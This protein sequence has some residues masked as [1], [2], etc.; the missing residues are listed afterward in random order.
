[1]RTSKE[2]TELLKKHV[3]YQ[4]RFNK[5]DLCWN[6]RIGF[7]TTNVDSLVAK[8][9][10]MSLAYVV[11]DI[12]TYH[13]FGEYLTIYLQPSTDGQTNIDARFMEELAKIDMKSGV[14]TGE[15]K[16]VDKKMVNEYLKSGWELRGS[17]RGIK[18]T[19]KAKQ[20][21]RE[22]HIG[23]KYMIHPD[24]KDRKNPLPS[25]FQ[26]FLDLGYVFMCPQSKELYG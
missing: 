5:V 22:N 26:K 8:M 15:Y 18:Q 2:I 11:G 19:E 9:Y 14:A 25:D 7:R 12:A 23:R 24:T 17:N 10:E 3:S 20:L 21:N 16:Y 6:A 4:E 13:P 1:M